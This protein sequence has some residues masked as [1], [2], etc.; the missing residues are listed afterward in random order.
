MTMKTMIL[1]LALFALT[2]FGLPAASFADSIHLTL[3]AP[4]LSGAPGDTVTF[5]ATVTAPLT[6]AVA[7]FLNSDSFNLDTPLTLDDSDFFNL[8]LSLNPGDSYTGA[9][10]TVSIPNGASLGAYLGS[11]AILGGADGGVQDLLASASFTVDAAT[12]TSAVPE[13][14]SFVLMAM[15]LGAMAVIGKKRRWM[16]ERRS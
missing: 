4:T 14:G 16:Y 10:F 9:L 6:N 2:A 7:M 13:P 15:G 8:P 5:D 1:T 3:S 12:A 11:F